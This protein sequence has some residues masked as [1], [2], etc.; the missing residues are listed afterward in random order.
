MDEQVLRA[1]AKW[2]DVPDCHEWLALDR[3]GR[4]RMRDEHAQQHGLLGDVVRNPALKGFIDR[5]YACN[6]QGAWFFQNGPQ[7]VYV[8]LEATPH[9]LFLAPAADGR[10]ACSTHTGAAVPQVHTAYVDPD[11]NFYLAFDDA[12]GEQIGLV[13]DRD[14]PTLLDGLR[15]PDGLPPG[16]QETLDLLDR[17]PF[18][19][20]LV[21]PFAATPL[22][23]HSLEAGDLPG[24]FGFVP[25]PLPHPA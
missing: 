14:L 15:G 18:A 5:N 12:G 25:R 23:L 8:N 22:R 10:L 13:C 24:R 20:R 11:G 4:W 3:R 1:L 16:P 19:L 7:R 17:S 6:A 21:L 2:P 9:V